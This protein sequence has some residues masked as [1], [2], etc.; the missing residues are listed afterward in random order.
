MAPDCSLRRELLPLHPGSQ[1]S[2]GH[3]P[4]AWD[5][6]EARLLTNAP[7][8][9]TAPARGPATWN[10]SARPPSSEPHPCP[11][12]RSTTP[13][14]S[15]RSGCHRERSHRPRV[16]QLRLAG[17]P[18]C[19]RHGV[20][21][22]LKPRSPSLLPDPVRTTTPAAPQIRDSRRHGCAMRCRAFQETPIAVGSVIRHRT[23]TQRPAGPGAGRPR[24]RGRPPAPRGKPYT[25]TEVCLP[26]VPKGE[27]LPLRRRGGVRS[28]W[29]V[30]PGS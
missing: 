16:P 28:C 7:R 6:G 18:G 14:A 27:L 11:G 15:S 23:R 20:L 29:S 19:R 8:G 13:A 9:Q 25:P 17:T 12:H 26:P 1:G 3:H 10:L 5:L 24:P 2:G 22:T 21:R 30:A 4:Q